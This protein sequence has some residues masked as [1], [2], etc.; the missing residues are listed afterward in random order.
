MQSESDK[1]S[2]NQILKTTSVFGA[3]KIFTVLI[4]MFKSKIIAVFLGPQGMGIFGLLSY[5][6][7]LAVQLFGLGINTSGIPEVAKQKNEQDRSEILYVIKY[8]N[9]IAGLLGTILVFLFAPIISLWSFGN[10]SYS[11][12]FR[13]LSSII[14]ISSIGNE[15]ELILRGLREIKLVA[16]AG[17]YSSFAGFI[18]SIPFYYYWGIYGVVAV[19]FVSALSLSIINYLY[20]KKINIRY[21]QLSF[22]EVFSRGQSMV[23]LG[24][25]VVLG[26][27]IFTVIIT[28]VNTFIRHRGGIE[29]VGLFQACNQITNSSINIVLMAMA[30]D[31]FPKLSA[32]KNDWPKIKEIATQQVEIAILLSTPIIVG[33]IIFAPAVIKILLSDNFLSIAN[34]ISWFVFGTIFRISSWAINFVI[35]ANGNSKLYT[36]NVIIV[37]SLLLPLYCLG[38]M[39]NGIEGIGIAYV[40]VMIFYSVIQYFIVYNKY[41][42]RYQKSFFKLFIYGVILSTLAL[43][44]SIMTYK[45]TLIQISQASILIL[46]LIFSIKNIN[47][48]T[49]ILKKITSK[50]KQK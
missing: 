24:I 38:Y 2:Y 15:Y 30:A 26:D 44:V 3:V 43:I 6:L 23:K 7:N 19:I 32:Y 28:L 9:R 21:S 36:I 16:K 25:F 10:D 50:L 11:W 17:F 35:L 22:K 13:I 29:D 40:I 49:D 39:L 33:M 46:T 31:Y 5:P 8:W 4:N 20:V 47:A 37:N 48:K 18:L 27:L 45:S 34:A 12:A 42:F 14:I 1:S 41:A